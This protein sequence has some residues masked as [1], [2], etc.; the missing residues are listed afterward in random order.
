[1]RLT[2]FI[3]ESSD[4][5]HAEII[6][7]L[8]RTCM[9]YLKDR[10]FDQHYPEHQLY[11]GR[12]RGDEV[13]FVD[14]IRSNREPKD[15][16]QW[17]HRDL[18]NRFF[19]KFGV[20]AR[21]NA[22]FTTGSYSQAS[23]YGDI[24]IIFPK[25]QYTV[26]WSDDIQ[27][28][29]IHI[30][31]IYTEAIGIPDHY[32]DWDSD[33][34]DMLERSDSDYDVDEYIENRSEEEYNKYYGEDTKGGIW[35]YTFDNYYEEDLK[36]MGIKRGHTRDIFIK[37]FKKEKIKDMLMDKYG[38]LF[39]DNL[40]WSPDI[41][42]EDFVDKNRNKYEKEYIEDR[43]RNI[44]REIEHGMKDLINNYNKGDIEGAIES[45]NEVMLSSSQG[46]C[47]LS[48]DIHNPIFH[49]F[50]EYG[51]HHPEDIKRRIGQE[52]WDH[53]KESSNFECDL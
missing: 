36:K 30:K 24:Y 42:L 39:P 33:I 51:Y 21:S 19:Q 20:R 5:D 15:T 27:D 49:Y 38:S 16:P 7:A 26:I 37:G 9:P 3:N 50:K 44:E 29:Y 12:N 6:D 2:T 34:G 4:Y 43:V 10:K 23:S 41:T 28:L 31:H 45:G 46:Y 1:M 14:T 53:F 52:K 11:S 8:L 47:A 13:F 25:G 48:R 32:F 22:L 35:T 18:D 40:V 17:M